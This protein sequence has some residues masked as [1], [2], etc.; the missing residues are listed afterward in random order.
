VP[1]AR[2]RRRLRPRPRR[3]LPGGGPAGGGL[4]GER[5]VPDLGEGPEDG[6][7]V[8]RRVERQEVA[9]QLAELVARRD[10]VLHD[11]VHH[12]APEVA[13]R[14][15][16]LLHHRHG[17][18]QPAA[19]AVAALHFPVLRGRRLRC[20]RNAGVYFL[21][22]FVRALRLTRLLQRQ[23]QWWRWRW[24]WRLR[25]Q[26]LRFPVLLRRLKL[27][28]SRRRPRRREVP[29]A[30]FAVAAAVRN[31]LLH[32]PRRYRRW[33]RQRWRQAI[34]AGALPPPRHD[35]LLEL[36]ELAQ[37][38]GEA[39]RGRGALP[40]LAVHLLAGIPVG[41][42]PQE[43]G[44]RRGGHGERARGPGRRR[45]V[46][47]RRPGPAPRRGRRR[48]RVR[49]GG[50][51]VGRRGR[52]RRRHRHGLGVPAAAPERE[53]AADADDA[54][55]AAEALPGTG[56]GAHPSRMHRTRAPVS[57]SRLTGV[58]DGGHRPG[59]GTLYAGTFGW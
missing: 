19:A 4:G 28:R 56:A 27:E 23:W 51:G 29:L 53:P 55:D 34:L 11:H 20:R 49:G 5:L 25:L 1:A 13:Q 38:A 7:V 2:R 30:F 44:R 17:P 37:Q 40:L 3:G 45:R 58:S 12:G 52:R 6:V 8:V 43:G 39:R 57:R 47:R 48:G 59:R 54:R 10:P 9:E 32:W 50:G 33:R 26:V 31:S 36:V 16:R 15:V 46:V 42:L 14:V 35:A 18:V 22:A 41:V 21:A 24:R